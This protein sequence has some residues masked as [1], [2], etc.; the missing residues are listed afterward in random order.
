[1]V[2][3]LLRVSLLVLLVY[4][5]LLVLTYWEFTAVPDRLHPAAGQGLSAAERA[6]ARLGLGASG[7]TA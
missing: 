2:G 7:P 1:M 4:G 6:T 3:G 5:G